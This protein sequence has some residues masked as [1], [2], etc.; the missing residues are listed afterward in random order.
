MFKIKKREEIQKPLQDLNQC[1]R[2]FF[3]YQVNAINA[4]FFTYYSVLDGIPVAGIVKE[5]K[6]YM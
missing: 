4:Y 5:G 1:T 2:L 3:W 6:L